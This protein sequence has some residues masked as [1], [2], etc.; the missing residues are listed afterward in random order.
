MSDTDNKPDI[1][2]R[3]ADALQRTVAAQPMP[4][5]DPVPEDETVIGEVPEHLR[6]LHNL[7]VD[8][9]A[10]AKEAQRRS[11]EAQ[12]RQMLV[13][14]LFA[15][16]LKQHLPRLDEHCDGFRLC[17]GWQ[18]TGYV[19]DDDDGPSSLGAMVMAAMGRRH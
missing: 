14:A 10:E 8:L 7:L 1:A 18:V 17:E 3:I 4:G 6:H 15:N 12:E 2:Q 9:G 11:L 5:A 13:Q 16:A 19:E